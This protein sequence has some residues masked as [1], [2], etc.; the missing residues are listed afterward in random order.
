MSKIYDIGPRQNFLPLPTGE[1]VITL[2]SWE[3][4]AEE[5]DSQ[6]SKKG[7]VKIELTWIVAVP[8][9]EPATRKAR[10]SI[11]ASWNEKSNFVHAAE[12]LRLVDREKAI[13]EG[14]HVNWDMGSGKS[15]TGTIVKKLKEGKTDEWTD[16]ITAYAPLP[17]N[18]P[19]AAPERTAGTGLVQRYQRLIKFAGTQDTVPEGLSSLKVAGRMKLLG[20]GDMTDHA[21]QT[22][23]SAVEILHTASDGPYPEIGTPV[24]LKDGLLALD[25][26]ETALSALT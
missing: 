2:K 4:R 6:Y 23:Q 13:A 24:T 5:Q 22:L 10:L 1:Y 25:Q 11:P 12:A 18:A 14:A 15:C 17:Q 3:E 9:D 19:Q 20:A 21:R 7:D 26:I 16:S 8:N